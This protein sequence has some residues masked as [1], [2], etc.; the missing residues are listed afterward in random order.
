MY[1]MSSGKEQIFTRVEAFGEDDWQKI[2]VVL[3]RSEE[4]RGEENWLLWQPVAY[5][6]YP[7]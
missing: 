1:R 2:K 5:H 7:G 3:E 4:S 6:S